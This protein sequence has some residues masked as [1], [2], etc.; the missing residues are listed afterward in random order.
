MED[1]GNYLPAASYALVHNVLYQKTSEGVF[2]FCMCPGGFIVPAATQMGEVV[3]NGMSPSKRDSKFSNSGIVVT[4]DAKDFQKYANHGN[5]SGL[6]YQAAIE[7]KNFELAGSSQKA[8]AQRLVDFVDGKV[9]SSLPITSYQPGLS[10]VDL[11]EL[12]PTKV[13]T[14]LRE[15]FKEF[16]KKMKGYLTED[17]VLVGVE[18]RTSSP[19]K[20]PR[21]T[22]TLRHPQIKNLLPCGEGAGY[23][24][25]IVSAAIDGINCADAI[26]VHQS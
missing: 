17:A 18:S 9:S 1:R 14:V 25:G 20:I 22:E 4:V 12:L 5:L 8:S 6:E 21:D 23:A 7:R 3:V 16:G 10:S 19:V 15:G 26:F 2:S 11:K 24:G 13:H